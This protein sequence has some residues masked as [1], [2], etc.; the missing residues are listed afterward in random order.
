MYTRKASK[1]SIYH[2]NRVTIIRI[3][4]QINRL[5]DSHNIR[6]FHTIIPSFIRS[7][8]LQPRSFQFGPFLMTLARVIQ[9]SPKNMISNTGMPK[10]HSKHNLNVTVKL[11]DVSSHWLQITL[12]LFALSYL[13]YVAL[14]SY[15]IRI[16]Y[17][18]T[19]DKFS[20]RGT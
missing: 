10:S 13:S 5:S 15:R 1:L 18:L 11:T 19:L 17:D 14:V 20:T 6:N 7:D 4:L 9:A 3:C 12:C 8:R 2:K 16:S